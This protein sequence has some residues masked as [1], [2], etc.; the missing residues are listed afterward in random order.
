MQYRRSDLLCEVTGG[1]WWVAGSDSEPN[2][3]LLWGGEQHT[4]RYLMVKTRA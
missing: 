2:R 4:H 1:G 3:A